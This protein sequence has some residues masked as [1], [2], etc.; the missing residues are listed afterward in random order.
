M[1]ESNNNNLLTVL[2]KLL[3]KNPRNWH[4]KLKYALWVDRIRVKNV[5]GMSPF[6]I[7]YGIEPVFSA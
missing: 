5:L 4:N 7:V 3:N 2:R 1:A 6:E